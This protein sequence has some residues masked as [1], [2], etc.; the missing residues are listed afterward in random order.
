MRPNTRISR[1]TPSTKKT[2]KRSREY[3]VK[4]KSGMR[5]IKNIT[6]SIVFSKISRIRIYKFKL[7]GKILSLAKILPIYFLPK[8]I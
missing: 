3:V 6:D 4:P 1:I 5:T 2:Y 7:A 8:K